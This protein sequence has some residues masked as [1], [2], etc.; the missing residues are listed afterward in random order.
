MLQCKALDSEMSLGL[1]HAKLRQTTSFRI[2]L[3]I[4]HLT[5]SPIILSL[6]RIISLSSYL[7]KPPHPINLA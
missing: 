5:K 4:S 7:T 3:Q 6:L 1:F 2:F